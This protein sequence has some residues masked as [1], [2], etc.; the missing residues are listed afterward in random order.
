MTAALP[1]LLAVAAVSCRTRAR[2]GAADLIITNGSNE[3]IGPGALAD[4]GMLSDDIVSIDP[5][6]TRDVRVTM[7]IVAGRVAY[8][9]APA[10]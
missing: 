7:T 2:S 10:R 5:A 1:L 4:M 3:T 9:M 6:R 8:E